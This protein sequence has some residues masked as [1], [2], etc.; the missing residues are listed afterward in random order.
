MKTLCNRQDTSA[1]DC[2]TFFRHNLLSHHAFLLVGWQS[3]KYIAR[4]LFI[5]DL[6]GDYLISQSNLCCPEDG[7]IFIQPE[8]I[9][10][11]HSRE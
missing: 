1:T 7:H 6:A 3:E 5:D 8:A 11:E 10:S 9:Y 4:Q 2:P